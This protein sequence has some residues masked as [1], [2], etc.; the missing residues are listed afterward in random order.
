MRCSIMLSSL[1]GVDGHEKAP[2]PNRRDTRGAATALA[3]GRRCAEIPACAGPLSPPDPPGPHPSPGG[4][5]ARGQ[6]PYGGT[7]AGRLYPWGRGPAVDPRQ[8]PGQNPAGGPR[9]TGRSESAPGPTGRL[10]QLP[11]HLAVA[12][13]GLWPVACLDHRPPAG[14]VSTASQAEGAADIAYKKHPE[15]VATFRQTWARLGQDKLTE[16]PSWSQVVTGRPG[17]LLCED[18]SRFGLLPVQ[19]RRMTL[20]GIKPVGQGQDQFENFSVDGAV[21]PTTGENYLLELPHLY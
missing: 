21:E 11:S 1:T 14:A 6:S 9:H 13:A 16:V 12:A 19:R 20:S 3:Q 8:G 2:S 5:P 10:W 4:T 17:R 7:L 15:A 18:E